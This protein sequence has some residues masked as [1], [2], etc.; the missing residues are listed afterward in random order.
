MLLAADV[1]VV[2]SRQVLNDVMLGR[3]VGVQDVIGFVIV[4]WLVLHQIR[5]KRILFLE[6][7]SHI[8]GFSVLLILKAIVYFVK[9]FRISDGGFLKRE[10]LTRGLFVFVGELDYAFVIEF[11]AW[12]RAVEPCELARL[13]TSSGR[14]RRRQLLLPV[15]AIGEQHLLLL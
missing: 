1:A 5:Q 4:F 8:I 15:G 9:G 11:W 13:T 3:L 6:S 10:L 2:P 7:I 12:T 14:R